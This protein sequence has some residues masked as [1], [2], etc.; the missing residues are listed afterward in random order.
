MDWTDE[1]IERLRTLWAEGH[2]TEEIGRRMGVS[3]NAIV[4]KAHRLRLP[5]RPSPIRKQPYQDISDRDAEITRMS[6]NGMSI[7]AIAAHYKMSSKTVHRVLKRGGPRVSLRGIQT[8]PRL[9]SLDAPP[10]DPR[11]TYVQGN[12]LPPVRI[13]EPP[14]PPPVRLEPRPIGASC[15][16]PFGDPRTPSFRFCDVPIERGAT[17][18]AEHRAIA[19]ERV[20]DRREDAA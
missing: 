20:R 12:R 10:P 4:G 13:V 18:C 3:K 7:V 2:S 8:L 17:Y 9:S 19:Y 1:T 16:W 15:C 5:S 14:P 11:R 6:A